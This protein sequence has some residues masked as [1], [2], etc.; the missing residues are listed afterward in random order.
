M[1]PRLTVLLLLLC[2]AASADTI[3]LRNGRKI[4]A[5]NVRSDI[6]GNKLQYDVGDNTFSI[7]KSTVDHVDK[8]G[9]AAAVPKGQSRLGACKP[10]PAKKIA[11]E[12]KP[13]IRVTIA[14]Q[15]LSPKT[16]SPGI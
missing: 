12:T 7:A 15:Q 11:P 13:P 5:A 16:L 8:A 14:C 10:Q 1:F 9:A 2:S 6:A 4:V 3:Y